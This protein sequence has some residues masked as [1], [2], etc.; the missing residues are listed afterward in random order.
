MKKAIRPLVVGN[1]K[2]NPQSVTMA[3]RLVTEIKKGIS[4]IS[5]VDIVV[6]PPSLYL[7]TVHKVRNGS[8]RFSLG[9]Q[10]VHWKKLGAQTG[11]ISVPMLKS[12]RVSYAILG[13]SERRAMGEEDKDINQKTHSVVK[14]GM[15][16]V[17]CVGEKK[18]DSHAQY[19]NF[20]EN[21]VREACGGISRAKLNKLVIAYE[22]IWA[23]GTGDTATPHDAHEMKLFIQKVLSDIYGRNYVRS[24]RILYGGSVSAKNAESLIQDGTVDG[25]LVGGAS[26][27]PSEFIEIVKASR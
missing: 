14:A 4:R 11:E 3:R 7:E 13:H 19:L 25:F 1:W 23:I 26:L 6:A 24:I 17:V 15:T 9:V 18:R 2:M 20:V 10:N 22:P 27:R 16:A 5:D 21:Q 12:F 8:K